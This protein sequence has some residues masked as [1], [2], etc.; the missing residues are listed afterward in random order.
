MVMC[1]DVWC[2]AVLCGAVWCCVVVCGTISRCCNH[3]L[4]S[5]PGHLEARR[6]VVLQCGVVLLQCG[7]VVLQCGVVWYLLLQ[8]VANKRIL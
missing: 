5:S 7:V 3:R 2:C 6:V 1:G 4:Q 8:R